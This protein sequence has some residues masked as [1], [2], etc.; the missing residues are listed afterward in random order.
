MPTIGVSG[1]VRNNSGVGVIQRIIHPR[2]SQVAKIQESPS[3]DLPGRFGT[4]I[5][6]IQGLLPPRRSTNGYFC[7][8]SP[9]PF[10]TPKPLV[11]VVHDLRWIREGSKLKQMYRRWDLGRAVR[12]SA[13]LLC[14]SDQTRQELI[15]NFPAAAQTAQTVWLGP[16][17]VD[18]DAWSD[19]VTGRLLLVGGAARKRNELAAQVLAHLPEG[20][21]TSVVGIGISDE[22]ATT[23]RTV[24]GE[25]N[26]Q[27]HGRVSDDE[28]RQEFSDAQYYVHLGTDEGFGLPFVEALKSG[29][30]VI[31]VDQPLTREVLGTAAILVPRTDDALV[32]AQAWAAA[33]IPDAKTRRARAQ[34]FTWDDMDSAVRQALNLPSIT[35]P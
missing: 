13:R 26:V 8:V 30:T 27:I 32:L 3:R 5:G 16:G 28:M 15:E 19:G 18:D 12:R 4:A 7:T 23:C 10:L 24:L 17:V 35:T 2:L 11:Y 20:T 1:L 25:E 21:V 33:L 31:A 22:A 14:V 34:M 29:T 9:L 6:L